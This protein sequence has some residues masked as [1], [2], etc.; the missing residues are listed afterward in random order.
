LASETWISADVETSGPTSHTGSLLSIG[1]SLVADPELGLELLLR[2]V[3][4]PHTRTASADAREEAAMLRRIL[5]VS[6]AAAA[7]GR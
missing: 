5:D 4:L 3:I 1:A 7:D 2:P 6:R